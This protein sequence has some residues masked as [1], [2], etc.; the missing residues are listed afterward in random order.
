MQY[1]LINVIIILLAA[2]NLSAF[3]TSEQENTL[4]LR[5]KKL[6]T[7]EGLEQIPLQA[8]ELVQHDHIQQ[9]LTRTAA[10]NW[11]RGSGQESLPSLRSPVLTGAGACGAFLIAEDNIPLRP[12]GFCNINQLFEAHT[13]QASSIDI[14]A[15]P[16]TVFY[17]SN[18]LHGLININSG[19]IAEQAEHRLSLKVSEQD[20]YQWRLSSSDSNQESGYVFKLTVKDD[21]GFRENSGLEEQ[22]LTTKYQTTV[23]NSL[24]LTTGLTATNLRQETAGYIIGQNA[25]LDAAL[26]V[27]NL[28][29]EAYRDANAYRLWAAFDY[30]LSDTQQLLFTPYARNSEMTFMMHFLPGKP[31]EENDQ[32]S[33]GFQSAVYHDMESNWLLS[34]GIDAELTEA[35][36]FQYQPEA[37]Q[38]SVFLT[39]TLPQGR[40]YDYQVDAQHVAGFIQSQWAIN[41]AI[42]FN[43][44]YRLEWLEYDYDNQMLSGRSR[45]DG[46]ECGFGGCRYSRPADRIDTFTSASWHIELNH[47]INESNHWFTKL[48]Q[49]YR[50]PQATELYRLQ[51]EQ[52][53]ADLNEVEL[54]SFELGYRYSNKQLDAELIFFDMAKDN[55]IYRDSDYY[56]RSNGQTD[57]RGI[58]W[59]LGYLFTE[60][61]RLGLQG[62]YADHTYANN[63]LINSVSIIGNQVDT[64]PK[65]FGSMNLGWSD[66]QHQVELEY[67]YQGD[68]FL[69]IENQHQYDGHQLLNLRWSYQLQAQWQL[70]IHWLN[71]LNEAYAER[72]DFTSFSGYRYFPGQDGRLSIQIRWQNN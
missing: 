47:T 28:N 36:L 16:G 61:W 55:V 64:A 10:V 70:S 7:Q 23:T 50:A 30:Q 63:G 67:V 25:Y 3:E 19:D 56:N 11:Q 52:Q 27:S 14:Q 4:L 29:P 31:I 71:M 26:R 41:D 8:I 39:E 59:Q 18:A 72:A 49:G 69:D 51:R 38:G 68:Y 43:L 1:R 45:E 20:N 15:G 35:G 62:S 34:Y 37:F 2:T 24:A 65:Q 22:K 42:N 60:Q 54:R 5:E 12:A 13:E 32:S 58:E 17:G 40:Q 21:A 6:E 33:F 53:I 44:G 48:A 66:E 57:H 9:L 46:T